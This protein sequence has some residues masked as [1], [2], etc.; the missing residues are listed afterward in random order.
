MHLVPC[1]ITLNVLEERTE[2]TW[3]MAIYDLMNTNLKKEDI[4]LLFLI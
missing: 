2:L 3:L 1:S 4:K